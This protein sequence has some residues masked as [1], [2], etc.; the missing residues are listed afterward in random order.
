VKPS[1]R[2]AEQQMGALRAAAEVIASMPADQVGPQAFRLSA[3]DAARYGWHPEEANREVI[4]AIERH[5]Q[6]GPRR[7]TF[8]PSTGAVVACATAPSLPANRQLHSRAA[9][10]H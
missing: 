4:D 2:L 6:P 1:V 3:L 9:R 10:Q 5:Y 8:P 7:S